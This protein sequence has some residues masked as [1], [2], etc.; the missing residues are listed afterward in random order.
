MYVTDEGIEM[1]EREVHES[2][3]QKLMVF[4]ELGIEMKDREVQEEKV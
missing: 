3:A 2:K 4:T 1:E